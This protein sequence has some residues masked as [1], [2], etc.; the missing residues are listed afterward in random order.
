MLTL[1]AA[2]AVLLA[3]VAVYDLVQ[4][5]HAIRRNFPLVGHLRY[6]V[7]SIGPEL[8]QY[9]VAH[10]T[11]ERPFSRS[12]RR[13]VY[14]SSKLEN[15]YFGFG[16]ANDLEQSLNYTIVKHSAFPLR[17]PHAG[18]DDYDPQH[19]IAA[20]KVLGGYRRRRHAFRP[21]SV[22]NISG[23]SYGSLSG[24]AVHALNGGARLA[25][26]FQNT[27]EGGLS[28]HHLQGGD[29]VFQ[30][31]TGYF[32]CRTMDGRFDMARLK[33]LVATTPQI[34]A[35]E[36][37]MSQGAKPGIGGV[38]PRQKI[39]P[40]IAAIRGIPRDRDCVSP[41]AHSAFRDVSSLLDVVESI[42]EETGLPV[43]IKSAVGDLGFW[44]ELARNIDTS[45]RSIDF[46]TIDGG[47]G[48]TG[49]APPVFADRVGLP[50]KIGFS[51]VQLVFADRN[52]HDRL[53]FIGSG[54]L[55]F[56][57]AAL[58]AF[59][60]GCDLVNVGREALL[61]IGCIQAQKCHTNHC[62]TGVATQ[63]AW[64]SRG[65]DPSL[66]SV[67]LA[68]YV[69]TLRK[70]LLALTRACGVDHPALVPASQ[71]E[72]LDSRFGARTVADLLGGRGRG[73]APV[74]WPQSA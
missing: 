22:I 62:P 35:I 40:E 58:V 64:L 16:S 66:K 3:A 73:L 60:L 2:V 51:R 38:L 72:I 27:G 56:P 71:I 20:R 12:Q 44:Q 18:D 32:G 52:L 23:M 30:I 28:P 6:L 31:G 49:A 25:G 29:I 57:D 21:A 68:N 24:P 11:E 36:I 59:S 4:R 69:V 74:D 41:A 61:A 39:T 13:W 54:K 14:T 43:G 50:F 37:K 9:I 55:G 48:G 67:R 34:R 15:N 33:D 19:T 70:E 42:A 1:A 63:N 5:R 17:S 26:C 65:L 45:G 8:R 7:E 10:D 53:V 47:E 46:V